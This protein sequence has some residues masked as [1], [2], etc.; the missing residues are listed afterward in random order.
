MVHMLIFQ[1]RVAL[2]MDLPSN[3]RAI[4]SNWYAL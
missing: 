4:L 2:R 1:T 3:F